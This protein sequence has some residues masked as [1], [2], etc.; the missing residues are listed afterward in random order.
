MANRTIILGGVGAV[1][2][3]GAAYW[4]LY[5]QDDATPP[6][7]AAKPAAVA[8]K[9]APVAAAPASEPPK[10]APIA[11][12]APTASPAPAASPAPG[13]S[14]AALDREIQ[15]TQA[16]VVDLEKRVTDLRSQI[17]MRNKQIAEL[18]SRLAK[19]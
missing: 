6:K 15:A 12:A 19:R 17:E 5:M 10:P 18:E 4:F 16:K 11:S 14:M 1:I 13:N 8:P 7:V 2:I 3:A 9:P